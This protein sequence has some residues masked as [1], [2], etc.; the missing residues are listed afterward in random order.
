MVAMEYSDNAKKDPESG[1]REIVKQEPVTHNGGAGAGQEVP[2]EQSERN[3]NNNPSN[4]QSPGEMEA[5][6]NNQVAANQ[7]HQTA[8]RHHPQQQPQPPPPPPPTAPQPTSA[9]RPKGQVAAVPTAVAPPSPRQHELTSA[10]PITV[11]T[12]SNARM[13]S[14]SGDMR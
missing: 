8:V 5:S 7:H 13:I 6:H 4:G 10:H 2:M 9:A 12:A 14:S 3:N 11:I 1:E